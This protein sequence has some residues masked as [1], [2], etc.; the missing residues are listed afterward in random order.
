AHQVDE[1][2]RTRAGIFDHDGT[3][4]R[5]GRGGREGYRK[6]ARAGGHYAAAAR[7]VAREVSAGGDVRNRQRRAAHVAQQRG[8]RLTHRANRTNRE[9]NQGWAERHRRSRGGADLGHEGVEIPAESVLESRRSDRKV[10]RVGVSRYVHGPCGVDCDSPGVVLAIA[11][12]EGAEEL[13]CA[14]RIEVLDQN[15]FFIGVGFD[16]VHQE[17]LVA[18]SGRAEYVRVTV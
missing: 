15:I 14:S 12:E 6:C 9:L 8:V 1:V 18:P 17:S 10:G 2:R 13:S 7:A 5:S 11:T 4:A 3:E 16:R